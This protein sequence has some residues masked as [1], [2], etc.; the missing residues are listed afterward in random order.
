ML[1]E[2]DPGL[3][4]QIAGAVNM[5]ANLIILAFPNRDSQVPCELVFHPKESVEYS[6]ILCGVGSNIREEDSAGDLNMWNF[7]LN[8]VCIQARDRLY[9]KLLAWFVEPANVGS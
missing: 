4:S 2:A 5:A 1:A 7:A 3:K 9:S 8:D 6:Q